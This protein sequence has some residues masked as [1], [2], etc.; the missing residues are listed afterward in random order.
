MI[1]QFI[2]RRNMAGILAIRRK[3]L[4]NRSINLFNTIL[5]HIKLPMEIGVRIGPQ[6]LWLVTRGDCG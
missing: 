6:Y 3:T 1:Y 2:F 5:Y 4:D